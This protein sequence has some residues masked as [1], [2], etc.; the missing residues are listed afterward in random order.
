MKEMSPNG[1]RL[2]KLTRKFL[3]Y[4]LCLHTCNKEIPFTKQFEPLT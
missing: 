4:Q 2:K 1:N 3:G